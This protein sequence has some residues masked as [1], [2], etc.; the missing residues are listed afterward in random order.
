MRAVHALPQLPVPRTVPR[1]VPRAWATLPA[2][3]LA[4][5]GLAPVASPRAG[6]AAAEGDLEARAL[7]LLEARC[8]A[9]HGPERAERRL[10][11]DRADLALAGGRGGP[12]LAPGEPDASELVLRVES[13]DEDRVMPP[14]EEGALT[15]EERALLRAWVAAGAPWAEDRRL[16]APAAAPAAGAPELLAERCSGCHGARRQRGG[17]RL[18]SRAAAL[19][20][21]Y[22][23]PAFVPG[24]PAESE[25][26]RRVAAE[27]E[28][29]RMPQ[30]SAPLSIDEVELLRAWIQG[31]APWSDG[32]AATAPGD[33]APAAA[34]HW[35]YRP[36]RRPRVPDIPPGSDARNAIDAF[37]LARLAEAGVAP[38]PRAEPRAL[39]RR[40]H[41]DLVGLPPAPETADAF[42]A[43]PSEAAWE[44]MVDELLASPHFAERWARRWL[45]RARYADSDGYEKDAARRYAWLYRDWVIDAIDRDVPLDRF[46]LLQIAGDLVEDAGPAERLGTGFHRQTLTNKEAGVDPEEFRVAAVKDRVDTLG[47][48]WLGLTVGCAQCHDH[49]Y[50]ELSQRDYY[51]LYAFFDNADEAVCEVPVTPEHMGRW[52]AD[53]AAWEEERAALER[54]L[55]EA[56]REVDPLLAEWV[57]GMRADLEAGRAAA[58]PPELLEPREP[59]ANSGADLAILED[60]SLL[61]SG[62]APRRERYFVQAPAPGE[63]LHGFLLEVLP[64]PSLPGGGPGRGDGGAWALSDLRA[65]AG[66][67]RGEV[68]AVELVLARA[69]DSGPRARPEP[70]ALALDRDGTTAWSAPPGET[71]AGTFWLAQ[72]LQPGTRWITL[73]LSMSRGDQSAV[74]RLRV[75]ALLDADPLGDLD[76]ELRRLL[77]RPLAELDGAERA[78]LL[79]AHRRAHLVTGE[80]L[81]RLDDHLAE[82]PTEPAFFGDVLAERAQDRRETRVLLRGDFLRPGRAVEPSTPAVLPPL[83]PR[84]PERGADRLDLARWLVDPANPL[85]ARVAANQVWQG[86]FARGLVATPDDFGVRGEAPSHPELLDWL[87]AELPRLGWSRKALVRA[88]ALSATY[89]RSSAHRPELAD[90]DPDNR[91]LH[92]QDRR[93]L[94]AELVRDQH[95]AAA[96]LLDRSVGGPSVF[97]P[98]QE[99]VVDK[100]YAFHFQWKE[101]EGADRYRRGLYTFFKRTAPYPDLIVFD[102]PTAGTTSAARRVSNTPLQAL[103]TLNGAVFVEAAQALAARVLREVPG[104]AGADRER[105]ARAFALCTARPPDAAERERLLALL[106]RARASFAARPADA[107]RFA[108]PHRP[109]DVPAPEAAAWTALARAVQNLDESITRP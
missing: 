75:S 19:A 65:Y 68:G 44:R 102:C 108:G 17:L 66:S 4:L 109:D 103:A 8:V 29:D 24:S 64:H 43:D 107:L 97:P 98:L 25:L 2:L 73:V 79:D 83:A 106:E 13:A 47:S 59:R 87:A 74:G 26:L 67:D 50:D 23:G 40:L 91:L 80:V 92:R 69:R 88:I 48:V 11:L 46:A 71:A 81:R 16:A 5:A 37:V 42:A 21:G 51:G 12:A 27:D 82:E 96:G 33:D 72:P 63:A 89:R 94:D 45:D 57:A 55:G 6:G 10:R 100:S 99:G 7:A 101:S 1:T 70:A 56:A 76:E 61:A 93:R 34:Q 60:G 90:V 84:D 105:A 49:K 38:S 78:R 30:G 85:F 58:R 31:G 41:Y 77:E 53:R 62:P 22:S 54:E 28:E 104:G 95:L 14:P 86:L 36:V 39:V 18:D 35:A 20:G 9:C 32:P 3:A 15:A 52:R